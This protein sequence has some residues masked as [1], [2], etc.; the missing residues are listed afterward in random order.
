MTNISK[1]FSPKGLRSAAPLLLILALVCGLYAN[2]LDNELTYWDDNRYVTENPRVTDLSLPGVVR[3][4]NPMDIMADPEVALTEYLPV[5][6][7]AH[8]VAYAISG[9]A[10]YGYHLVNIFFYLAC[11][12]LLYLLVNTLTDHGPTAFLSTLI[13]AILPVHVESVTWVSATKDV[14]SGVFFLASFLL[15]IRYSREGG[16]GRGQRALFYGLSLAAFTLAMLSKTLVV[17]LPGLL[18]L[19]DLSF[20]RRL[21]LIDKV[22]Y[23]A[24]GIALS[25]LYIRVNVQYSEATYLTTG[26]GPWGVLLTDLTVVRDYMGMLLA[27]VGLNSFYTYAP[28]DIPVSLFQP[29]VLFSAFLAA[30]VCA[31]GVAAYLRG[32]RIVPFTI[33]WFF[34]AL[35]PSLNLIPS[36]TIKADRYLFLPSIGF[37]LLAG[38]GITRLR[39]SGRLPGKGITAIFVAWAFWLAML[40]VQ[41]NG[42]WQNGITLWRDSLAKGPGAARAHFIIG[43]ELRHRGRLDEAVVEYE[44]ALAANPLHVDACNNLG[45]SHG[46]LGNIPQAAVVLERCL[47]LDPE[48]VNTRLN[49]ARAQIAL[50]MTARA[51]SNLRRVLARDPGNEEAG[52]LMEGL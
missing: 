15:Y 32:S 2:T 31:V 1:I 26:I 6:T 39:G 4:F 14:V 33:F 37:S 46:V 19:Y 27:P 47:E 51:E 25:L 42:D 52:R 12:V 35:V 10:P 7:L 28:E 45:A 18:L 36:S 5:T 44:A 16:H 48:N 49:L 22:P 34:I 13:F 40:T 30:G 50:G 3:I 9:L 24:I 17:T 29:G 23:F 11:L 20:T 21:R 38:W 41:R 43:N 8:A